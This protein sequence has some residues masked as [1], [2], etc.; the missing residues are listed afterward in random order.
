MSAEEK[1]LQ[2]L[3]ERRDEIVDLAAELIRA[4]SPNPPG[5]ERQVVQVIQ[6]C[7]G[8]YGLSGEVV[9]KVPHRPNLLLRVPGKAGARRLVMNGHIDTKPTG[10][11]GKWKTDPYAPTVNDGKMYGLGAMDMKGQAAA[12]TYAAIALAAASAPFDGELLI[13]LSADEEGGSNYGVGYLVREYGLRA[14]AALIGEPSGIREDWECMAVLARGFCGFRIK[15]YGTQMHSSVSDILP[16]VN[17]STKMG[18]VLWRM[19][20]DLKIQFPP[21]PLCPGGITLTPGV[22]VDGGV[23]YGVCPGFAEFGVD[24][25]TVPGMA[26]EGVRLDVEAFLNSLR[27]EDPDLAVEMVF[28][29]GPLGWNQPSEISPQHPLVQAGLRAAERVL[30]FRPPLRGFPGATDAGTFQ[31]E[32]GIPAIPAFG[33]GLLPLAHGPDEYISTEGIVQAAKVYAL[34]ALLYLGEAE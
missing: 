15:V 18:Y 32:A 12:L 1:V 4:P 16:S 8:Q 7:L 17:A 20:K 34:M 9:A 5:D 24:L 28:E 23:Y 33:P 27:E 19:E 21:H 13:A 26:K 29:E 30:G 6:E 10:D 22:F 3:Q 2:F 25:R 31:H 14:D 11:L